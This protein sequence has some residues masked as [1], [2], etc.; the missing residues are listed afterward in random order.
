M[1]ELIAAQAT[2]DQ[3]EEQRLAA[4]SSDALT[5]D[6]A[7]SSGGVYILAA[8]LGLLFIALPLGAVSR[9]AWN[10]TSPAGPMPPHPHQ[11]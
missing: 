2:V 5:S 7:R 3:A 11:Y 4:V 9:R 1:D 6:V 10:A 8:G